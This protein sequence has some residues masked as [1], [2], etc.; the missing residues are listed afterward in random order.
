VRSPR[1]RRTWFLELEDE[2]FARCTCGNPKHKSAKAC[3]GERRELVVYSRASKRYAL[4][5][6]EPNGVT[7]RKYVE[8][9]LGAFDAPQDPD[10]G[11]RVSNWERAV[12]DVLKAQA[13]GR[14]AELPS[15]AH[16]T[17]LTQVRIST[18]EQLR[19]FTS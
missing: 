4:V 5:N 14:S 8:H 12:W 9:L 3:T 2:N 7:V 16:Q 10:T 1:R 17:A 6:I 18:P 19:W 13:L 11:K 15:W